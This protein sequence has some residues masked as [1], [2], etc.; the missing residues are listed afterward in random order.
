MEEIKT[1]YRYELHNYEE[2]FTP[3]IE[4]KEYTVIKE[5]RCGYWIRSHGNYGPKK[6]VLS[7]TGKRFAHTTKKMALEAFIYRRRFY[8]ALMEQRMEGNILT[9]EA[10]VKMLNPTP[11]VEPSDF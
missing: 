10:A 3:S 8:Q 1:L 9:I 6:F 7:G 5:T 2:V 4:V 11:E